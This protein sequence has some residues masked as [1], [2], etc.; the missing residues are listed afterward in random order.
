MWSSCAN[1]CIWH[2]RSSVS[3]L[4]TI[5]CTQVLP[6]AAYMHQPAS[7]FNTRFVHANVNKVTLQALPDSCEANSLQAHAQWYPR[8]CHSAKRDIAFN[9]CTHNA[10]VAVR[11]SQRQQ[12][13]PSC[14]RPAAA[15]CLPPRTPASLH[16]G[17]APRALHLRASCRRAAGASSSFLMRSELQTC[18]HR[19]SA[20]HSLFM[21]LNKLRLRCRRMRLRCGR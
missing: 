5:L 6:P 18:S 2:C 10:P 16:C 3:P 12:S 11:C 13:M 19:G 9:A 15:A 21:Y 4:P 1:C 17:P 8:Q 14:G 7:S 20:T